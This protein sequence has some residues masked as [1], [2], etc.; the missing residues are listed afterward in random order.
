M[1]ISLMRLLDNMRFL[2]FEITYLLWAV[3]NALPSPT[4]P[5]ENYL[6]ARSDASPNPIASQYPNSPTG[7]ING[8]TA[9]VP[10]SY[11]LA[12]SIIPAK[13]PI[14]TAQYESLLPGFPKNS[15]P[16]RILPS[17]LAGKQHS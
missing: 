16:V 12:R 11:D 5:L 7:T 15:Y 9:V 4:K 14:L 8:T 2:T 17:P 10:I 13:Y 6:R 3:A 1:P